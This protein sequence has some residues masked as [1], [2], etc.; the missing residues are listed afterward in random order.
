MFLLLSGSII[1]ATVLFPLGSYISKK[2]HPRWL[3]LIGCSLGVGLMIAASFMT[4]YLAFLLL[5]TL[6]FGFS[7]GISY[8]VPVYNSWSHYPEK[9]G[10]VTGIVL[11]GFGMGSF[12]FDFI[13]VAL[14]NPNAQ[15]PDKQGVYSLEVANNVPYMLRM[16]ALI[17][18]IISTIA[19]F[20]TFKVDK[21]GQN[22][23]HVNLHIQSA[24][25]TDTGSLIGTQEI[26]LNQNVKDEDQVMEDQGQNKDEILDKND[27][28]YIVARIETLK[29]IIGMFFMSTFRSFSAPILK[30]DAFLTL[31]GSLGGFSSGLRFVWS[32]LVDYFGYKK[33][34]FSVLVLQIAIATSFIYIVE[35][36]ALCL[37]YISL[38]FWCEG[39]HYTLVPIIIAKLFGEQATMVYAYAFSFGGFSQ[40]ISTALTLGLMD[41]LQIEG[42]YFLGA[43][44]SGLSLIILIFVFQ[45]KQFCC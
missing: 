11:C 30:D 41:I 39:G 8:A 28:N 37:I 40:L 6:S 20:M 27:D 5:Y 18:T 4:N 32:P 23:D 22:I 2:L 31:C 26:L 3:I 21:K 17:W 38:I 13:S 16:L 1:W 14:V 10:M 7:N 43:I 24:V 19:F 33:T 44:F 25:S 29:I 12:M 9:K 35:I 15:D 42:F 34:Y 45:E 36:K